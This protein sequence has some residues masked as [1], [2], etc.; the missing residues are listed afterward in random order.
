MLIYAADLPTG[1]RTDGLKITT[2]SAAAVRLSNTW[3]VPHLLRTGRFYVYTVFGLF[4][5]K[6]RL[7]VKLN[8]LFELLF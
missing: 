6:K 7:P 2:M 8:I 3:T 1:G 4:K 5:K